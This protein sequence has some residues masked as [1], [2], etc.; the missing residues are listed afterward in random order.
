MKVLVYKVQIS[1]CVEAFES[2]SDIR[3]Q[4]HEQQKNENPKIVVQTTLPS[5]K[6]TFPLDFIFVTDCY[7]IGYSGNKLQ[8]NKSLLVSCFLTQS[9]QHT[10]FYSSVSNTVFFQSVPA[11]VADIY[12]LCIITFLSDDYPY[13][14]PCR[15]PGTSCHCPRGSSDPCQNTPA[16][17]IMPTLQIMFASLTLLLAGELPG[18]LLVF[19]RASHLLFFLEIFL[20]RCPSSRKEHP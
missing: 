7:C 8:K 6:I 4:L 17:D 3:C 9:L 14:V 10:L 15:Q 5:I 13:Q 20:E 18:C 16:E 19:C 1:V 12:S 2:L 11:L